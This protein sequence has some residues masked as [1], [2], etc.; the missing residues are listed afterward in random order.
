M[1]NENQPMAHEV[2]VYRTP[3]FLKGLLIGVITL[4]VLLGV[5]QLGMFVGARK[6]NFA[7]QRFSFYTD[8]PRHGM[9]GLPLPGS[10]DPHGAAGVVISNDGQKRMIIK[11]PDGSEKIIIFSTTTEV[12]DGP[13]GINPADVP[14]AGRVVIFGNPDDNGQIEAKFIRVFDRR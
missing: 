4:I 1:E 5:F 14:E 2:P 9:M 3:K 10:F 8:G 11:G 7:Y 12:Q 6:A 13:I